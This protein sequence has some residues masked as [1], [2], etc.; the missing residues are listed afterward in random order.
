M[1]DWASN[2]R[3][4]S[5]RICFKVLSVV[6]SLKAVAEVLAADRCRASQQQLQLIL[7]SQVQYLKQI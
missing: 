1:G 7:T 5:Y 6:D 4:R 2:K 3:N